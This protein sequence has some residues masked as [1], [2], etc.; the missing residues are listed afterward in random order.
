[1][2]DLGKELLASLEEALVHASG[3]KPG[4]KIHEAQITPLDVKAAR[5]ALD[6]TQQDFAPL[7]GTSVSGLQ[8]W[9]QGKRAPSGA[10][11][12]LIKLIELAPEA[13]RKA[14]VA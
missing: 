2:S 1:M 5:K 13:V 14:L 11:R 8:K 6:M 4:V 9:E 7:L 10:A 3:G 12:T